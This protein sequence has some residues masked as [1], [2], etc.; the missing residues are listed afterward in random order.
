M[1]SRRGIT[2][3]EILLTVGIVGVLVALLLPAIQSAR[4]ASRRAQC[5][6]NL[7][8][9]A[10]GVASY[11]SSHRFLP[12]G[13]S[14]DGESF[15][16]SVL[17]YIDNAQLWQESRRPGFKFPRVAVFLCPSDGA[18]GFP[19]IAG[20]N[21]AGCSGTRFEHGQFDGVFVYA[22]RFANL[23]GRYIRAA[24]V[25]DGLSLTAAISELLRA[26]GS[27]RRSRVNWNTD[28]VFGPNELDAFRAYCDTLPQDPHKLG[29]Q[30]DRSARGTPWSN[31]NMGFTLYNHV[32]KPNQAS[33]YNGS[34]VIDAAIAANSHH[35]N[36]ISLA[37]ADGHVSFISSGISVRVWRSLASRNGNE[38][39]DTYP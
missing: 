24:E 27:F 8:Q 31:G 15:L 2:V 20:A 11:E 13:L 36:G 19:G 28:Q 9:L 33:C 17:P 38:T 3:V 32:M 23:Q 4:E 34:S 5:A 16:M 10:L 18:E 21:Y 39:A 22:T 14:S 6:S 30:G 25:T 35:P 37:Y 7:R 12:A 1:H 26:D 29:W